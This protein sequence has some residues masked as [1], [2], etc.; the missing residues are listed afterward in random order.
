MGDLDELSREF[1][2]EY[3]ERLW[4]QLVVPSGNGGEPGGAERTE[5]AVV[6]A[7]A[8]VSALAVKVPELFGVALGDE[9]AGFYAR[10]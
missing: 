4:K 8:V 1:A 6:V 7:L 3:S 5:A 2:R 10:T 9:T